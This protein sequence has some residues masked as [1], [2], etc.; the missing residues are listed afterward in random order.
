MLT[1]NVV[2]YP[3]LVYLN[4]ERERGRRGERRRER[5]RR[6]GEEERGEGR[7]EEG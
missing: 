5:G 4:Q 2:S 1:V 7:E 6:E 3:R